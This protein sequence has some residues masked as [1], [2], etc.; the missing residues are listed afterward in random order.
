ML[1]LFCIVPIPATTQPANKMLAAAVSRRFSTLMRVV[2]FLVVFD[3]VFFVAILFVPLFFTR[4]LDYT[5][6]VNTCIRGA[7]PSAERIVRGNANEV[8]TGPG[9]WVF[10]LSVG[11]TFLRQELGGNSL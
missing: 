5:I 3:L 7:P 8:V 1:S 4:W 6:S 10:G 11:L 2:V 9:V